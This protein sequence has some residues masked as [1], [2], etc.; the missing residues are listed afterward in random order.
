MLYECDVTT[1]IKRIELLCA[2]TLIPW[3]AFGLYHVTN[4]DPFIVAAVMVNF[5]VF[6]PLSVL[7]GA[8]Y[9]SD[10][11]TSYRRLAWVVMLFNVGCLLLFIGQA[12]LAYNQI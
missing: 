5:V 9:L 11:K 10:A 1:G 3:L 8:V 2:V 7:F 4:R 12:I 6:V